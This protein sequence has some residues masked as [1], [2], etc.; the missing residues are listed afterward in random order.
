MK[1]QQQKIVVLDN[2][3]VA[4]HKFVLKLVLSYEFSLANIVHKT[5]ASYSLH[6]NFA[7]LLRCLE[8]WFTCICSVYL[9]LGLKE[10]S[11]SDINFQKDS[12]GICFPASWLLDVPKNAPSREWCWHTGMGVSNS[13]NVTP[14][15]KW[16]F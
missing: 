7:H 5:V 15:Y 1:E 8:L 2:A 11:C 12:S 13:L 16:L 6:F 9:S 4:N 3:E 14:A 10:I